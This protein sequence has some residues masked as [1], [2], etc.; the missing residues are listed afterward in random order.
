MVDYIQIN[1]ALWNRW[2]PI[3]EA[4]TFYDVDGFKAG[5]SSLNAIELEEVGPVQGKTL[6]H[7]QC[8]FGLDS[9]SWVRQG[10]VVTG[11]D[12]SETAIDLAR[13][14]RRETDLAAEFICCNLFDLPKLLKRSFDVVF[15]SYGVLSWLSD[16][17]QWASI[18]ADFL[19]PGGVFYIVEFHPLATT[20]NEEGTA[21]AY[22]YLNTGTPIKET[23]HGCYSHPEGNFKADSVEWSHGLG[24]VVT[25]LLK[26]GLQ[27]EFLHEFDHAP[28]G[29]FPFTKKTAP[30]RYEANSQETITGDKTGIPLLFSIRARKPT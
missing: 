20:L 9:L 11:V 28:Y 23:L 27:L 22:P 5:K 12:F 4:S 13:N 29:C 2:T 3:N 17:D 6:L 8:H 18:A 15:T 21:L 14:L 1:R 10:A 25:T 7:L 30:S 24:E 26:A 19:K 16:L